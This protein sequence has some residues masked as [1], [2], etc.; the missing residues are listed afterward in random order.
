MDEKQ[1]IL[2]V[3]LIEKYPCLYNYK[4][5]EYAKRNESEKAWNL[6]AKEAQLPGM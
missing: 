3:Q 1:N 2:F 4:L 6:V 5:A